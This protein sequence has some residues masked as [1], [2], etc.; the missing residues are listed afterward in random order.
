MQENVVHIVPQF[1]IMR[2]A[3]LRIRHRLR[4]ESHDAESLEV[5]KEYP[6]I[7]ERRSYQRFQ[8]F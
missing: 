6:S 3:N 4:P 7:K 5:D 2:S 1:F 8:E